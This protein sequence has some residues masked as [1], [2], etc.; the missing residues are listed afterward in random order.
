VQKKAVPA[1][2]GIQNWN[3]ASMTDVTN[4]ML[5]LHACSTQLCKFQLASPQLQQEQ[6]SS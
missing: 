1:Q 4:A 2:H 5:F 3:E 6:C